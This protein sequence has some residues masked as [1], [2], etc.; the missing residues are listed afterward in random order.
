MQLN[1]F[2]R[3]SWE[4]LGAKNRIKKGRQIEFQQQPDLT[5]EIGNVNYTSDFGL[6]PK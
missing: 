1:S 6:N 2:R 5:E 4:K 3:F